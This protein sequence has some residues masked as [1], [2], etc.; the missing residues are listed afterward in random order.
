MIIQLFATTDLTGDVPP[1]AS[2][3][4]TDTFRMIVRHLQYLVAQVLVLCILLP[5]T[6]SYAQQ[7]AADSPKLPSQIS[8]PINPGILYDELKT[9]E[10]SNKKGAQ[11]LKNGQSLSGEFW[12]L[13]PTLPTLAYDADKHKML[14]TIRTKEPLSGGNVDHT[15]RFLS[16]ERMMVHEKFVYFNN[17][18]IKDFIECGLL[19]E[20]NRDDNWLSF[21]MKMDAQTAMAATSTMKAAVAFRLSIPSVEEGDNY[22]QSEFLH[23]VHNTH[24]KYLRVRIDQIVFYN[25]AD[26]TVY[27]K[28]QPAGQQ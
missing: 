17:T 26:G 1:C 6:Q 15:K 8:S 11:P 28:T 4:N 25:P 3:C 22:I 27:L 16:L 20:G 13:L 19:I 9:R 21:T 5:P 24:Y 12:V 10:S 23:Y 7:S 2:V 18:T 14:V